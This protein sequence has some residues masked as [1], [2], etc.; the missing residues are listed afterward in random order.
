MQNCFVFKTDSIL[1][2]Q[3]F[4]KEISR[5]EEFVQKRSTMYREEEKTMQ[6][7]NYSPVKVLLLFKFGLEVTLFFNLTHL[8]IANLQFPFTIHECFCYLKI[9]AWT[10]DDPVC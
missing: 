9:I 2:K 3:K 8:C 1:D 6:V 4:E 7:L 10:E 5:L